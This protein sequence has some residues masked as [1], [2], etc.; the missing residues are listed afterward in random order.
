MSHDLKYL[1]SVA[2]SFAVRGKFKNAV[3]YGTGHINDTYLVT[4]ADGGIAVPY[5]LQ[6][7]NRN[8]FRNPPLLM[9]NIV[10]VTSH[11][12]AKLA[13]V[14]GSEPDRESLTVI[15]TETALP[16]LHDDRDN[17]WRMYIFIRNAETYDICATTRQAYETAF[18]FGRFQSQLADLPGDRLHETIPWF[19]HTPRRFAALEK[20]ISAD[21]CNRCA[22]VKREIDF[23]AKRKSLASALTDLL[24]SG[25]IPERISHNDSKINN[26]MM[27]SAN[28]RGIC[29]IDLDTVMSGSSLYDFGDMVRT[30]AR[31]MDEDECDLDKVIL[32]IQFFESLAR[33]YLESARMFL[34]PLETENMVTAGKVI[35]FT[36]GIR[37]LADH[38]MND[39]YFKI[40]RPGHNLDRAR[41]QF[42]LLASIEQQEETMRAIV[43][44][45]V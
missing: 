21:K 41:V 25:R 17:F 16:F 42:K 13:A 14:S 20:A 44:Q 39:V 29:V 26:V 34:T 30:A 35:T 40:H 12:R 27:D 4:M 1:K 6:R 38:L 28:G 33:G 15:P 19:H 8:I 18:A 2:Q 45:Y 5:I 31:T 22:E 23:C 37:F 7:I 10:R 24:E 9:D 43:R 3:P 36:I 11:I 32:N